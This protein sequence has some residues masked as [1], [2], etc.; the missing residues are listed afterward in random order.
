[1]VLGRLA[2]DVRWQRQRLGR[3]L[4]RDTIFTTIEVSQIAGVKSLLVHAIS[5]AA[6]DLYES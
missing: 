3:A 4:L 5:E 2:V 1:M 6:V